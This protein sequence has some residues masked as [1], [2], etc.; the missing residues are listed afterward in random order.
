MLVRPFIPS[1]SAQ[2][3]HILFRVFA[4]PENERKR[5]LHSIY[6]RLDASDE[7]VKDILLRNY[8]NIKNLI[9]SNISIP[10]EEK[11]F[12]GACFT[13]QYALESTAL[14]NPSIVP[15]PVQDKAGV[16]KFIISLRAI[17]EGHISSL[18]FMDGEIDRNFTVTISKNSSIIYEPAKREYKYERD[19]CIRKMTELG[20]ITSMNRSLFYSLPENFTL[21]D[22]DAV[23]NKIR[24]SDIDVNRTEMEKTLDSIRSL[25]LSNFTL[26]FSAGRISERAI[27]PAAPS[28]QHGLEDARFVQFIEEDGSKLYYATFTA[29]DG[30]HIMSELLETTDFKK[31]RISTLGGSAA[32]NKGMALFPRKINGQYTMLGR[33]DNE[34]LYIMTSDNLYFWYDTKPLMK[35]TYSWELIQIGNCGS[36][37]E[38]DEGWLVL[39]HGVGP[40]RTYSLGAILLDKEEPW[41]VI[42]RLKEP[43]ISPSKKEQTVYVPNVIYTCG[44]MV[45]G[46]TLILPYAIGD[47][48]TT[49]A[50]VSVDE[51]VAAMKE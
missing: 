19:L 12:I 26:D 3:E 51:L 44:A 40:V 35:P 16:T 21:D 39:T 6:D 23:L 13:Q 50:T 43:L 8:K 41:R 20:L 7:V 10:D 27:Y 34:S 47:A 28:Q 36:P 33:Q 42:G 11:Q 46:R 5:V 15:H 30:E 29:Y 9:P 14:F 37:I 2:I 18:T 17:G 48:V 24:H 32:K 38:I 49:F 45:I 25:A 4:T 22:L 31:F 1:S